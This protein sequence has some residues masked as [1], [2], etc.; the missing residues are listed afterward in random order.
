MAF[1][2][3]GTSISAA[4]LLGSRKVITNQL[5]GDSSYNLQVAAVTIPNPTKAVY[6]CKRDCAHN[7][8]P[9]VPPAVM[10]RDIGTLQ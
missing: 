2:T 10:V 6:W 3:I 8:S 9:L 5:V 1:H 7:T 4:N